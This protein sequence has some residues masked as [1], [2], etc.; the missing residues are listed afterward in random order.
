MLVLDEAIG[1]CNL[2]FMDESGL[3]KALKEKPASL[4]VILT[5]RCPLRGPCRTRRIIS[6]R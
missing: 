2:G 5:G 6:R 3:I 4:E 1:A